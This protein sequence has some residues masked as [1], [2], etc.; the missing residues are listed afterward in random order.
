MSQNSK[1][2]FAKLNFAK[3][4]SQ[5]WGG[6]IRNGKSVILQQSQY[7]MSQNSKANFAKLGWRNP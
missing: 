2:N 7:D 1:A 4:T 6:E 3:L 5:S